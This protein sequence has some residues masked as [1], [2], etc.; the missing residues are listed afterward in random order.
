MLVMTEHT[1][2]R[3][4][5]RRTAALALLVLAAAAAVLPASPAGAVPTCTVRQQ[6]TVHWG[7]GFQA[8]VTVTP[9]P[10]VTGWTV[11]FDLPD[12]QQVLTFAMYAVATQSGTHVTLTNTPYNGTLAAGA[13]TSVLLGVHTNPNLTNTP[14]AGFTVDRRPC[15]YTPQPYVVASPARPVVPEGG[16]TTVAVRLSQAPT[17]NATIAVPA[18]YGAFTTSP[19]SLVF[20][21]A[22]WNVPQTVTIRSAQDDDAAAQT[23]QLSFAVQNHLP[24]VPYVPAVVAYA[25]LDDD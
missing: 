5:R 15:A 2:S 18:G 6:V 17:A 12:P 21:P 13:S 24:P 7:T 22:N 14:P 16:S 3:P 19:S 20:T 11:E 10:A 25:Q 4:G 23:G 8:Q 9:G 1:R